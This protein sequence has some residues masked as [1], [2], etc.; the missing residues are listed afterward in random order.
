MATNNV[1]SVLAASVFTA[2]ALLACGGGSGACVSDPVQYS[3][4]LRVYCYSNW[5]SADCSV[6]NNDQVNGA[7]WAFYGGQTCE[8][9][10]LTDGSNP[11]P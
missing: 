10:S 6:N 7:N 1:P 9:R 3:F 11:W 8:D 5:S 2:L 4:G